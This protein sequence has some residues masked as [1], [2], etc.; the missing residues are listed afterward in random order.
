MSLYLK[1]SSCGGPAGEGVQA[2]A[3]ISV[4]QTMWD[5]ELVTLWGEGALRENSK[6]RE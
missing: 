6:C 2:H 5:H 4:D 3:G 1:T